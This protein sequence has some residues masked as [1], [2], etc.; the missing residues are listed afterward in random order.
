MAITP[1]L[2]KFVGGGKRCQASYESWGNGL[3]LLDALL[4]HS[5]GHP[6]LCW[7]SLWISAKLKNEH[8]PQINSN[9]LHASHQIQ[10]HP[11]CAPHTRK[12]PPAQQRPLHLGRTPWPCLQPALVC[13]HRCP[14]SERAGVFS[15]EPGWHQIVCMPVTNHGMC[16]FILAWLWSH[17]DAKPFFV[18][19]N[20]SK[21]ENFTSTWMWR[22]FLRGYPKWSRACP[23]TEIMTLGI[24]F[25]H[26]AFT[27]CPGEF[28]P[29]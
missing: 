17:L 5:R 25:A 29:W 10:R 24:Q 11:L 3:R 20:E 9:P 18:A 26:Y 21:P 1:Q 23:G 28:A 2:L 12:V 19:Q 14:S 4:F 6:S 22:F 16:Y 15:I 27:Q 8:K 7:L 13:P